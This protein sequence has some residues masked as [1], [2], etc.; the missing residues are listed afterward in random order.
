MDAAKENIVKEFLFTFIMAVI[1]LAWGCL[2]LR[3]AGDASTLATGGASAFG[4]V[5]KSLTSA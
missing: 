1:G 5:F 4:S 2:L 3:R